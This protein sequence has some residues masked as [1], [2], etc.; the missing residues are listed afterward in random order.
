MMMAP[1]LVSEQPKHVTARLD[2]H[3]SLYMY[4]RVG[5]V[6]PHWLLL[7]C[8]HS[9]NGFIWILGTL[10][11]VILPRISW[12]LR[13][14]AMNLE[15]G[16]L[17]DLIVI[18]VLKLAVRRARPDYAEKKYTSNIPADKYSFP[19]GHASRCIFIATGVYLFRSMCHPA[20]LAG[21]MVWAVGTSMSRVILGRHY[22]SDV[23][24]GSV[25]GILI[26]GVLSKV[27]FRMTACCAACACAPGN[28]LRVTHRN[29]CTLRPASRRQGIS[30]VRSC[31][32]LDV[33]AAAV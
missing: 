24:V 6:V 2:L 9:G 13:I 11:L 15:A 10:L 4:Q 1:D 26:G 5:K 21:T 32:R 20:I 33:A 25:I 7:A 17:L 29:S 8:E 31:V 3:S 12:K 19:S 30:S 28:G 22:L 14:F 27:C 23:V 16:F 18:G